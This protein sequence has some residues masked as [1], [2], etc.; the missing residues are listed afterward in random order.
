MAGMSM[1]VLGQ[2]VPHRALSPVRRPSPMG[3]GV[4][5]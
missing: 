3:S 1:K 5:K 4:G 2:S